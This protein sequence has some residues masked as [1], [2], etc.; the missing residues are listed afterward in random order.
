MKKLCLIL[1]LAFILPGCYKSPIQPTIT[2]T[3]VRITPSPIPSLKSLINPTGISSIENIA[4][5][6]RLPLTIYSDGRTTDATSIC[7]IGNEYFENL[8]WLI[9]DGYDY[10]N[11]ISRL[12]EELELMSLEK[13]PLVTLAPDIKLF[14]GKNRN[15]DFAYTVYDSSYKPVSNCCDIFNYETLSS[16]PNGTYYIVTESFTFYGGTYPIDL[17]E[18]SKKDETETRTEI[19]CM[20]FYFKLLVQ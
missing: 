13:I 14:I 2:P 10:G 16:L 4:T 5:Y 15:Y 19:F 11:E 3:Q 12:E 7:F 9:G 8:G 18:N 20:R 17:K 1:I 6:K